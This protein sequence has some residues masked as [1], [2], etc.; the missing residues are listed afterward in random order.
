MITQNTTIKKILLISLSNIGDII[1]TFPVLDV[2]KNDFPNASLAIV[3]GQKGSS[4]FKGNTHVDKLY[5]FNKRQSW[6]TTLKFLRVLRKENFDLVVDLRNTAIPFF[7]AARYRTSY[8]MNRL[9]GQHMV[10]QHLS[11]LKGIYPF[12]ERPSGKFALNI[13]DEDRVSTNNIIRSEVGDRQPY[14]VLAPGAADRGKRWPE[15]RFALLGDELVRQYNQRIVL[16]GDE[17]DIPVAEKVR[18][19]MISPAVNLCGRLT[20][21]Q[22]AAMLEKC[23]ILFGNDSAPMH[24]ASYLDVPVVAIFGPTDP[25]CYGPWSRI[26]RLVERKSLCPVCQGRDKDGVHVCLE[27]V[28]VEDVLNCVAIRG[29]NVVLAAG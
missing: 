18:Q 22:L 23:R 21:T 14:V 27:Q 20:L 9:S 2:L 11:R 28:T 15:E 8:L 17:H 1:L 6:K 19:F 7:V 24:L 10:S 13:L 29:Q 3:I 16:V 25:L 26:C 5:I 4:L 12:R